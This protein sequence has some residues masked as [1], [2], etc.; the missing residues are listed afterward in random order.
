MAKLIKLIDYAYLKGETNMP[1][2]IENDVVDH[3]IYR[4]QETMRMLMGDEFYQDYKNQFPNFT[5]GSYSTLY[6]YVK[7]YLAWQAYEYYVVFA[8]YN[9]T[10][11]GF[12]IHS[13][14][15]SV[16][17]TDIQ[18]GIII[19]DAKQQAQQYKNLLVDYLNGHAADFPLY[20][21]RCSTN[22]TGNGF[23]ISAVKNKHRHDKNCRCGCHD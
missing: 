19:K 13:E 20:N 9:V 11:A 7:Q 5:T 22:L 10:R 15:N 17:A 18:M 2:N 3:D 4:A 21:Q 14:E 16:P 8:N 6:P 12:R 1:Q 23:H